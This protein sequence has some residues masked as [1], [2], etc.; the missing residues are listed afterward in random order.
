ME[1]SVQVWNDTVTIHVYQRSKSVWIAVGTYM[2][3]R[4]EVKRQTQGA[5]ISGWRDAAKYKGG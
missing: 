5:A 1:V 2:E 3:H 4:I